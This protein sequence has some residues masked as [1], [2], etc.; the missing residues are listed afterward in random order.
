MVP[1]AGLT[2]SEVW[3]PLWFLSSNYELLSD[4]GIRQCCSRLNPSLASKWSQLHHESMPGKSTCV[5]LL[6]MGFKF[7]LS[8]RDWRASIA[9]VLC[10]SRDLSHHS[11]YLGNRTTTISQTYREFA[12]RKFSKPHTEEKAD[13]KVRR[14]AFESQIYHWLAF[15]PSISRLWKVAIVVFSRFSRKSN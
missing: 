2:I 15:G 6:I 14:H 13:M 12:T 4:G 11:S 8:R 9:L 10:V 5:M 3:F 1:F 7:Q